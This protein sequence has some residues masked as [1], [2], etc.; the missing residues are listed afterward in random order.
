LLE[1]I[2]CGDDRFIRVITVDISG[3]LQLEAITF[4]D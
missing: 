1:E 2:G 3:I 4:G